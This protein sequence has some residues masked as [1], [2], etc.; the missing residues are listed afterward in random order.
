MTIYYAGA[1]DEDRVFGI[2][3]LEYLQRDLAAMLKPIV[4]DVKEPATARAGEDSLSRRLREGIEG[5]A[6]MPKEPGRL[7]DPFVNIRW[8]HKRFSF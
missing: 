4:R 8:Y 6:P 7:E 2:R 5:L 3:P 1:T